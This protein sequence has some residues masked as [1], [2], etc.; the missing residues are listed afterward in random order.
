MDSRPAVW[1]LASLMLGAV[2]AAGCHAGGSDPHEGSGTPSAASAPAVEGPARKGAS[3]AKLYDETADAREQIAA[4]LVE[5]R[6]GG[7]RVLIQ[8]GGNWCGWCLRLDKLL[9]SD[10]AIVRELRE[11]Y[12]VVHVDT[13]IPDDKN[14]AL[15]EGY[16]ARVNEEGYPYLTVLGPDGKAAANHDSGS[17]EFGPIE[18]GHDPAKVLA[19]LKHPTS[20]T[21]APGR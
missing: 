1:V 16:G 17:F 5:A 15:A 12:V 10:P 9:K 18:Q 11:R 21:A 20:N 13:G 4:A 3:K 8:W 14:V 2:S 7:K 19:W 6:A